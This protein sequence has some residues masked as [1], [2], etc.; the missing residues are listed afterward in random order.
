MNEDSITRLTKIN[1]H[2]NI[3]LSILNGSSLYIGDLREKHRLV[4]VKMK[5][6]H[7]I[8][9]TK[10]AEKLEKQKFFNKLK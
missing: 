3:A 6:E 4:S 1:K 2:L 7:I 9:K 8:E 5:L 10:A